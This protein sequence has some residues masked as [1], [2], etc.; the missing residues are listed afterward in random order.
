MQKASAKFRSKGRLPT[1][2]YL[3][4]NGASITRCAQPMAGLRQKRCQEDEQLVQCIFSSNPNKA[5]VKHNYIVDARP[6]ARVRL[7]AALRW[8]AAR[9]SSLAGPARRSM[10]WRTEQVARDSRT[11]TATPTATTSSWTLRT[12]T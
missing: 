6:K 11:R 5:T 12:S 9:A 7:S 3:H 8:Q 10:P 1:L 2:S 4:P